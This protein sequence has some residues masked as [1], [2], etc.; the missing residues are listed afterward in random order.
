MGATAPGSSAS[1]VATQDAHV[2][3]VAQIV[4]LLRGAAAQ[5]TRK[6]TS[7]DAGACAG[8]QRGSRGGAAGASKSDVERCRRQ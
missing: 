7:T 4:H 1:F 5:L 6:E 2:H 8:R 3:A